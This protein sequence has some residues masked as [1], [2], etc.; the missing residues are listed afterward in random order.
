[1]KEV[2]RV[3]F[4]LHIVTTSLQIVVCEKQLDHVPGECRY[5]VARHVRKIYSCL[6]HGVLS[7]C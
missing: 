3:Y 6:V 7:V 5:Y 2:L 1:M 4:I